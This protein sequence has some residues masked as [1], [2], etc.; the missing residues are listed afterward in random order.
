[1]T[2]G[3]FMV[4]ESSENGGGFSFITNL[5][6]HKGIT[7]LLSAIVRTH[8]PLFAVSKINKQ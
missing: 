3:K 7:F 2:N 6:L 5:V 1:M 4:C 8:K